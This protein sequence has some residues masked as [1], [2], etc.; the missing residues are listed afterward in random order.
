MIYEQTD[1][2]GSL[3]TLTKDDAFRFDQGVDIGR[4]VTLSSTYRNYGGAP[5]RSWYLLGSRGMISFAGNPQKS[6]ESCKVWLDRNGYSVTGELPPE[7]F[8]Y[9]R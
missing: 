5:M 4:E 1:E 8:E 3:Y 9:T 7:A 2:L 6:I